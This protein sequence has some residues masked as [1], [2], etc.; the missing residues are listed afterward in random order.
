MRRLWLI[1]AMLVLLA[2]ARAGAQ[3]NPLLVVIAV[4]ETVF[5][6]VTNRLADKLLEQQ[7]LPDIP[8]WRDWV[9]QGW[10]DYVRRDN[11]NVTRIYCDSVQNMQKG[12]YPLTP[13]R[14]QAI[15]AHLNNAQE[16]I[17][18]TRDLE[19]LMEQYGLR[20]KNE[21]QETLVEEK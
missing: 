9:L 12:I 8:R 17:G 2:V 20:P 15:A 11:T 4:P 10:Q 16:R 21:E 1:G 18:V 7:G 13:E 19:G 6:S 5:S 14:I 3:D